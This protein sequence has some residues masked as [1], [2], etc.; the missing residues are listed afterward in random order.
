MTDDSVKA[1][2]VLK[3]GE[4]GQVGV[5]RIGLLEAI[6]REGSINA[7]AKAQGLSYK[8]AWDA[9]QA[10]NN[11]FARPLVSTQAGGRHGGLAQVTAEGEALIS[12]FRSVETEL[13]HVLDAFQRRLDDPAGPP[14]GTL[15][16]S[17]AMKTSARNALRGTVTR[18]TPGAVNAEV[19]L[20][21]GGGCQITAIITRHSIDDLGLEPGRAAIA[22]I[23]S[24]MVLLA[25]GGEG[26]RTSA[27]NQLSGAVV[28]VEE[29]AVNCEVVLEL[30]AG[31]TLVAT[32]TRESVDELDL[33]TGEAAIALIKASHVILAVE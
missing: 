29:G 33:R 14:L 4:R 17:L 25:K 6:R 26:L 31:K 32:V 2:L 19:A 9:V 15:L 27:R 5:D 30:A 10:L 3:R 7:A 11:L 18:V 1:G 13:A 24:S 20:D 16:W 23:K 12:A 21:I 28:Q 8:G 22:L